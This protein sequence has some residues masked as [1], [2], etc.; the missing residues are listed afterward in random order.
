M[1]HA[2]PAH[3]CVF[4]LGSRIGQSKENLTNIV[5]RLRVW[6]GNKVDREVQM[7]MR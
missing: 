7:H 5:A 6:Y 2:M 1:L 3:L 4:M